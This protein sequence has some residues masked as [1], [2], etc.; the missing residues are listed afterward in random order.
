MSAIGS[1]SC[2]RRHW[3]D[4]ILCLHIRV[5]SVVPD[6]ALELANPV[7]LLSGFSPLEVCTASTICT[8]L[9]PPEYLL[10]M[11]VSA[12]MRA[13]AAC[14]IRGGT[15]VAPPMCAVAGPCLVTRF[16]RCS[17]PLDSAVLPSS[18]GD[19]QAHGPGARGAGRRPR[20]KRTPVMTHCTKLSFRAWHCLSCQ[21]RCCA[22]R[23]QALRFNAR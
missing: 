12:A 20:S 6:E 14:G 8:F 13:I 9:F 15:K 18:Q 2:T 10:L 7:V 21:A 1:I 19:G 5:F 23:T 17:Q 11:Q 3:N 4:V 22:K 16:A